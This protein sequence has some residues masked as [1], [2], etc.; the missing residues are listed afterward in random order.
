M[1][2]DAATFT[3]E[4]NRIHIEYD[5]VGNVRFLTPPDRPAHE[6]QYSEADLEATYLSATVPGLTEVA[7]VKHVHAGPST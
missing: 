7:T 5:D 2:F 1:P 4:D 3:A 6:F